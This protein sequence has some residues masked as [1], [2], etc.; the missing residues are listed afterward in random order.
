M[1]SRNTFLIDPKGKIELGHPLVDQAGVGIPAPST[2]AC[3][4]FLG[5]A[6]G[7]VFTV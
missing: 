4:V 2:I 3:F 5:R 7:D 6:R 1:A